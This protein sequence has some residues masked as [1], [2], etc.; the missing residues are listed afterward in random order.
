MTKVL[1][2]G[3]RWDYGDP[4]RG[5]SFEE[6]NFHDPLRHLPGCEVE[7]FDFMAIGKEVGQAQMSELLLE[8]V[9]ATDPDLLFFV[10]FDDA[11]DPAREVVRAITEHT[12]TATLMWICDDHWRFED[13]SRTWAEHLDW[14]VTTDED[15]LPK[16]A[17]AGLGD[18]VLLSQWAVNHRLY[19]PTFEPA[20]VAVSFV[21]QPHGDR[22]EVLQRLQQ[23]GIPVQVAGH[24]WG[25]AGPRLPF[26]EM[27]RMFCRTRVN[28]NLA[29]SS[30]RPIPQIKG[31]NFE[32]PGC[33]ALLL[34][35]RVPHLE[36]YFELDR[37]V[38]VFS[39]EEE[40]ADKARFFLQNEDARRQIATRGFARCRREHTW[41]HRFRSLFA[42]TGLDRGKGKRDAQRRPEVHAV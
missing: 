14:I 1:Y 33:Q 3:M 13:Y 21:G 26:H 38:A 24:G 36:R 16:Y 28:L 7:Q 42:R 6:R 12:R 2:V 41:H 9:R 25:Q 31:R 17:A 18:G 37:E 29:N 15:A 39:S 11:H 32:V 27:V 20:D 23:R 22:I 5:L 30:C 35:P 8:R 40:L 19:R 34:T 10:G 4:A